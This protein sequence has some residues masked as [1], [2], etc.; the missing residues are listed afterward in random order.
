[1]ERERWRERERERERERQ[2]DGKR[3]REKER[4]SERWER[5]VRNGTERQAY[6]VAYIIDWRERLGVGTVTFL[7]G[8]FFQLLLFDAKRLLNLCPGDFAGH[9]LL[10]GGSSPDPRALLVKE[11]LILLLSFQS[12]QAFFFL[13]ILGRGT[14]NCVVGYE[15]D[16]T[17][18]FYFNAGGEVPEPSSHA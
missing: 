2:A 6:I 8:L 7:R 13:V 9:E 17:H 1:M 3:A 14:Q 5:T 10:G 4:Q 12:L 15:L 16:D 18:F 11:S